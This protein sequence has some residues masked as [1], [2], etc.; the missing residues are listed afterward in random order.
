MVQIS[1]FAFT[2]QNFGREICKG[3]L[4]QLASVI[5]FVSVVAKSVEKCR[6]S[7]AGGCFIKYFLWRTIEVDTLYF[8]ANSRLTTPCIIACKIKTSSTYPSPS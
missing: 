4:E 8:S 6:I 1:D 7:S 2:S 3:K 5:N